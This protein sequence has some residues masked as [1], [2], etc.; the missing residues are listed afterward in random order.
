ML[1]QRCCASALQQVIFQRG[2]G[3]SFGKEFNPS[4]S[5][6]LRNL[7]RIENLI[8]IQVSGWSGLNRIVSNWLKWWKFRIEIQSDMIRTIPSHSESIPKNQVSNRDW[9][10][11]DSHRKWFE[12]FFA[13]I[14]NGLNL[15]GLI[16]FRTISN[17]SELIQIKIW[18]WIYPNQVFNPSQS[19]LK[20]IRFKNLVRINYDLSLG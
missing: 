12:T 2:H 4:Q 10:S 19:K 7:F 13:L 6:S 3:K 1:F 20:F 9:F 16:S 15:F 11:T 17:Q 14:R 8:W 5:E 18:I